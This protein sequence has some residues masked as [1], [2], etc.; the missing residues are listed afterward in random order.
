MNSL[1][2]EAVDD[3]T[4]SIILDSERNIFE[5]KGSSHP[6]DANQLYDPVLKWLNEYVENSTSAMNF[7]FYFQYFNS[8]SSK[9]IFKVISALENI[10]NKS[11]VRIYWHYDKEDIDMLSSGE[12]FAKMSTIPFEF[13]PL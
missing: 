2:I 9:Q 8:S 13:L 7:S 11:K 5:I 12:H 6:E 10:A 1:I 4:P 3:S